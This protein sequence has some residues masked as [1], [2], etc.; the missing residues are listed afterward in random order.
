MSSDVIAGIMLVRLQQR[1]R[2]ER[3]RLSDV[4]IE[5]E[6]DAIITSEAFHHQDVCSPSK[7]A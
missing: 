3:Y 5:N 4:S 1:S 7:E 6:G 2:S